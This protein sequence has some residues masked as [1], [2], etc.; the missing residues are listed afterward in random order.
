MTT[1]RRKIHQDVL[2]GIKEKKVKTKRDT[3]TFRKKFKNKKKKKKNEKIVI[4]IS[5]LGLDLGK[6]LATYK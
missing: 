6:T 1:S 5:E 4:L 2:K 3:K